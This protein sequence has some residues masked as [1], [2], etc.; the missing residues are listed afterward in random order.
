MTEY[1]FHLLADMFPLM[2]G[3][4]FDNLVDDIK[5][6]G[7]REPIVLHECMVLDGRNRYRACLKAG[8]EPKFRNF[9]PVTESSP[10]AFVVSAN[11]HRRHLN[12]EQKKEVAA[13]MLRQNAQ[14]SDRAIGRMVGLDNKTVGKVRDRVNRELKE[15]KE[16]WKVFGRDQRRDFALT[17]K[18]ELR[19]LLG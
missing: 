7:L 18:D 10:E 4:E 5:A 17:F 15:F 1:K 3:D 12:L 19:S 13:K 16:T 14:A 11:A 8:V 9:D 6:N 2:D